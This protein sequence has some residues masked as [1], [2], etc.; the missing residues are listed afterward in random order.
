M[1]DLDL[2][3]EPTFEK[4]LP[5]NEAGD[6]EDVDVCCVDDVVNTGCFGSTGRGSNNSSSH[7]CRV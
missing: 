5:N 6:D 7:F 4:K 2:L 1:C 3:S